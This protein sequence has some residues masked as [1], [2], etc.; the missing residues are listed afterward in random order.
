MPM[1]IVY[2]P[3]D[4]LGRECVVLTARGAPSSV[5]GRALALRHD[6]TGRR[7][8]GIEGR[9]TLWPLERVIPARRRAG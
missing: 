5:V 3:A 2:R 9:R 4:L 7:W 8:I 1:V 6:D